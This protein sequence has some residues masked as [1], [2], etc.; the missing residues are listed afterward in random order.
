MG[1]PRIG[2]VAGTLGLGL[3]LAAVLLPGIATAEQ[4][5]PTAISAS[6]IFAK[7]RAAAGV[8]A[9][10]SYRSVR[11]IEGGGIVTTSVTLERGGDYVTTTQSGDFSTAAG[12]SS[13]QRW[14]RDENGI[15][16]LHTGVR[17]D[18]ART[19]QQ[20]VDNPADPASHIRVLGVT[21]QSPS[22]VVELQPDP[23]I[24]Q[25]RYYDATTFLMTR[26]DNIARSGRVSTTLY[27]DYRSRF[28]REVPFITHQFDGRPE[29]DTV[30]TITAF[31]AASIPANVFA[32]PSS[33]SLM[34]FPST[35]PMIIPTRV[36][37]GRF[38]IRLTVGGRGLDFM[39]DTGASVMTIDTGVARSLGLALYGKSGISMGG[40]LNISR[41]RLPDA[42]I[43][44]VH[45]RN[46]VFHTVPMGDRAGDSKVVGLL[47]LDFLASAVFELDLKNE[48]LT[49]TPASAFD[50][51]GLGPGIT[52][53]L[54]DGIPRLA[55]QFAGTLGH[56]ALDYGA[57]QTYVFQRF[58]D[59]A[60][61]APSLVSSTGLVGHSVGGTFL[62]KSY[63]MQDLYLGP[64]HFESA[65][66][67]VP[68]GASSFELPGYDGLIGRNVL[69]NFDTFLDYGHGL[70][71]FRYER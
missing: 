61:E 43:G 21:S 7:A 6:D 66:I 48:R 19:L 71:Y 40:D 20:A 17:D 9:P 10:G 63:E 46:V 45:L 64:V 70:A 22:Y 47:G 67:L 62:L 1:A 14:G 3:V 35:A 55:L 37:D 4:F 8:L 38:V 53:Q 25:K 5:A 56:F 13:G 2:A 57:D 42:T 52:V 39:L 50:P 18:L 16:L 58:I 11:R 34:L 68:V 24:H 28:G 44:A 31:T 60:K 33:R 49:A 15:V 12:S 54:D 32:I 59:R 36:Q 27:S 29:N 26:L 41:T 51:T 30:T 65:P 23:E 69:R